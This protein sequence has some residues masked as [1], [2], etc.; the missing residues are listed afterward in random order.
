MTLPYDGHSCRD[1]CRSSFAISLPPELRRQ[2]ALGI[3][4]LDSP[5]FARK[6]FLVL[7]VRLGSTKQFG[8]F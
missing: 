5:P 1:G 8:T 6:R 4:Y 7:Q 3:R 2:P